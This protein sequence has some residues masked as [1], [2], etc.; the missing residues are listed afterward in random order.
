MCFQLL[1]EGYSAD[2]GVSQI[3]WQS[4]KRRGTS[5]SECPTTVSAE[6]MSRNGQLMTCSGAYRCR[7]VA[8]WATGMQQV[9]RYNGALPSR[10][11]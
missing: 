2:R 1:S 11:R 8:T 4:V 7:R 6:T 9:D 3:I 10:H 5:D